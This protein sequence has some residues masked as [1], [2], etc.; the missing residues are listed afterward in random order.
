MPKNG[1]AP[2][3]PNFVPVKTHV[4]F[5]MKENDAHVDLKLK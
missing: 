1:Y 2:Q 4:T 5:P 3:N